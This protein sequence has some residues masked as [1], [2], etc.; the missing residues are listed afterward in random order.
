M[1]GFQTPELGGYGGIIQAGGGGAVH[2]PQD[3]QCTFITLPFGRVTWK[4]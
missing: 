4:R 1:A 2:P 3:R